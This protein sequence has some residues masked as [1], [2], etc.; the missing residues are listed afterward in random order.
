[1]EITRRSFF[2]LGLFSGLASAL[3]AWA[4]GRVLTPKADPPPPMWEESFAY[5]VC[6]LCPAGCGMRVRK[7]DGRAVGVC[8]IPEHPVNQGGLC[9]KGP[10]ALQELYHPDRLRTPLA[11]SGARGS[12]AWKEIPWAEAL[13]AISEKFPRT[14]SG[15]KKR[16]LAAVTSA[17]AWDIQG[18]AFRG[19]ADAVGKGNF[20]ALGFPLSEAPCDAYEKMHGRRRLAFHVARANL[21]VSFGFDWLQSAPSP[22]EAQRA[23]AKL[24]RGPGR[25]RAQI[26]QIEPRFSTTAGKADQWVPIHPGTEGLLAL[27]LAKQLIANGT[28]DQAFLHGQADGFEDFKKSLDALSLEDISRTTG[29]SQRD[30]LALAVKLGSRKPSAI[31]TNRGPLLTQ[32]AVHAL[33]ALLGNIGADAVFSGLEERGD[34]GADAAIAQALAARPSELLL[35]DR[36][37]PLFLAPSAWKAI[38]DRTPLVATISSFLT[39]TAQQSDLILPC[40]T[41]LERR[42]CSF[43]A[44]ADGSTVLNAAPQAVEPFYDTKDPAEIFLA[45]ARAFKGAGVVSDFDSYF[46]SHI[47]KLRA[48]KLLAESNGGRIWLE[49]SGPASGKPAVTRSGKFEFGPLADLLRRQD[50]KAAQPDADFPMSVYLYSPLAFS[51]GEGAHLPFLQSV[52]GPQIQEAWQ[53]WAELHPDSAGRFGISDGDAIWIESREGKI[54]ARARLSRTAMPGVLSLPVGLGHAA[55]GR[56]AKGM[57]ANPMGLGGAGTRVRIWRA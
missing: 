30:I 37:N 45:L 2:K 51:F 54:Q 28:Y 27:A 48:E 13:R 50:F 1:M 22:I 29:V 8:G 26:I 46:M 42:H 9:P 25:G 31:I 6:G 20:F 3:P 12:G 7:V 43:H 19:L 38:L 16:P 11:R 39:E 18:E 21:V 40:H 34:F 15:N 35:V 14:G 24:R 49:M 33:N 5:T 52:A 36:V 53:T 4:K 32:M 57:G 44:S 47:R 41:P 17:R 55:Y 56:W 23:Y 10:A